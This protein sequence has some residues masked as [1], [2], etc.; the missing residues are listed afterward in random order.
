LQLEKSKQICDVLNIPIYSKEGFEADDMLG[1]IVE[2]LKNKNIET[3]EKIISQIGRLAGDKVNDCNKDHDMDHDIE[4]INN[5]IDKITKKFKHMM[6][7][8]VGILRDRHSLDEAKKFIDSEI[9]ND[10]LYDNIDKK[11]V[12][13]V[14]ML[15]V[16]GLIVKAASIRE[17]SRG[18]H[19]RNDFPKKDDKNWGKHIILKEGKVHFEPVQ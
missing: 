18:T 6:S 2:K 9:S 16:G 12:E 3:V 14:N 19:Q 15:T 7:E 4:K 13:L 8:K 1:T 17:E 11:A 5:E 10:M